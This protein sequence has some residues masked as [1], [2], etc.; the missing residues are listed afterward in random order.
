[1]SSDTQWKRQLALFAAGASTLVGLSVFLILF[2]TARNSPP[3]PPPKPSGTE[4]HP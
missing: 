4:Q 1:M 3:Q 2:F